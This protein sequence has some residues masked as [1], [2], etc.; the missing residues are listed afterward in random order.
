MSSGGGVRYW[1]AATLL[2]LW[3]AFGGHWVELF[4]LN[5]LRPRISDRRWVQAAARLIVWFAGGCLLLAGMYY[6]SIALHGYIPVRWPA[7]WVG[8][9]AF[10][11]IELVTHLFLQLRGCG[12]F[13]SGRG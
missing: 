6:T 12:S 9:I 2:A 3:P 5:W 1:P 13:Y 10:I 11:G 4:F 8:G 7:W